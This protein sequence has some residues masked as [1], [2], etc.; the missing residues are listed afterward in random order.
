[1]LP[2]GMFRVAA[3]VLHLLATS[4]KFYKTTTLF[5]LKMKPHVPAKV[6]IFLP[7]HTSDDGNIITVKKISNYE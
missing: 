4:L 7:D 5:A 2:S 3:T 1:M 6:G